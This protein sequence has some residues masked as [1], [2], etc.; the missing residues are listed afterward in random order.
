MT[1][2]VVFRVAWRVVVDR[3]AWTTQSPSCRAFS[4]RPC[5]DSKSQRAGIPLVGHAWDLSW[6]LAMIMHTVVDLQMRAIVA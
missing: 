1:C 4:R 3:T 6:D 2:V 5:S